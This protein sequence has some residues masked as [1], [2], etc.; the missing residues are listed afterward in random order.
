MTLSDPVNGILDAAI[1]V[2]QDH[3]HGFL[4]AHTSHELG[5]NVLNSI[6]SSA[7][8]TATVGVNVQMEPIPVAELKAFRSVY[9]DFV[10]EVF[11]AKLLQHWHDST[12]RIFCHYVDLHISGQRP[13][14]DLGKVSIKLDFAD[15]TSLAEQVRSALARDFGFGRYSDRHKLIN[16]LRN[17]ASGE[18]DAAEVIHKHVH[19]RNAFQHHHGILQEFSL[20]ELGRHEITVIDDHCQPQTF[21]AGQKVALSI[22]ELDNLRRSLLL[23]AQTWRT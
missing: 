14:D 9:P 15:Q 4:L 13:F 22:A 2:I 19:L 1:K 5:A 11:H 16:K 23:M 20:K 21:K 18:A 6:S 3:Y 17:P 7:L 8:I 12:D 10:V